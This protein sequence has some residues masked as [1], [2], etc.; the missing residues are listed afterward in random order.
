MAM[1]VSGESCRSV[2]RVALLL[3]FVGTVF[4]SGASA[5]A[6]PS[7]WVAADIGT[8][9]L[10]GSATYASGVFTM[11]AAGTDIWGTSDQ[12][13]FVYQPITGDVDVIARVNSITNADAWSKAGVMIRSSLSPGS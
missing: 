12:F 7:P 8:P 13:R 10:A 4:A 6:V 2:A 1:L 9:A 11:R 5:Q 3:A